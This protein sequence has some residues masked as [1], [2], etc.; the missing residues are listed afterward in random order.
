M[1]LYDRGN[2]SPNHDRMNWTPLEPEEFFREDP[3]QPVAASEYTNAFMWRDGVGLVQSNG[4]DWIPLEL[5]RTLFVPAADG[6]VGA[7]AG[8]EFGDD[9]LARLP[10]SQTNS[11]L[12]IPIKGLN[13]GD[14]I[15]GVRAIGQAESAG[16]TAVLAMSVRK[17]TAAAGDFTDA[18][19]DAAASG[20]MTADTLISEAVVG[21]TG[22]TE[23]LASLESLYVLLTGTTA[24]LT[25][26]AVAGV[27]VDVLRGQ[28]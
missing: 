15:T 26:I 8:W 21:V 5:A 12:V 1:S 4:T 19:L 24:A 9:G 7:T 2:A 6:V 20:D 17:A 18:E 14:T 11:T 16:A 22:L 13:I 10:A 25:D 27:E 3:A 28:G 23:V